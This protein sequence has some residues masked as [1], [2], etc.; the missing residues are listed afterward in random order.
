M[1]KVITCIIMW[2]I[3]SILFYAILLFHYHKGTNYQ[4]LETLKLSMGIIIYL[5][6]AKTY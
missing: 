6:R 2:L 5:L 3:S 1:N 4:D